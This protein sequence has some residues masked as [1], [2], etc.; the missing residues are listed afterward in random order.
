MVIEEKADTSDDTEL[1]IDMAVRLEKG[2]Q[3]IVGRDMG[4]RLLDRYLAKG[5]ILS[6][7][8][9]NTNDWELKI[10]RTRN[11]AGKA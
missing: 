11:R 7:T 9:K 1:F 5:H 8:E 4:R 3:A 6:V 10:I 2:L